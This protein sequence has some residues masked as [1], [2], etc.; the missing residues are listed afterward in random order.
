MEKIAIFVDVQNIYYTTRDKY[1]A[2]FDYNQFWYVATEGQQV[3]SASAY[4]IASTDPKQRQF[5]HILRGIGFDVKLKPYIQRSDGS[6]KGDWDVGIALDVYELASQVDRVILLSG[7]GD[8]EML[9]T[10]IQQRFA[11]K[12]D[13]YAVPGLTAQNLIDVCDKFIPI[14]EALLL[15]RS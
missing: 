4:A 7:D 1:R 6:T 13:V 15:R 5:H 2:N 9:V 3:V 11:T 8:F 14:D 12:V 10:R